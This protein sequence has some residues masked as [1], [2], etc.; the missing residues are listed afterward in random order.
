M[1]APSRQRR[2]AGYGMSLA[3]LLLATYTI[4]ATQAS[5]GERGL[6]FSDGQAAS[7]ALGQ[8]DLT[9]AEAGAG[10]TGQNDAAGVAFDDNGMMWVADT[11]NNRI[12][13]YERPFE[14]GEAATVVIGQ[15]GFD[16][17]AASASQTGLNEPFGLSFDSEGNMWVAD[18][19]NNRV[20]RYEA[21]FSTGMAASLVLGQ[22]DFDDLSLIHI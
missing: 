2:L 16:S 14:T 21:P 20:V 11:F 7:T 19:S 1:R 18:T 5:G 9:T 4:F 6:A 10:A 12:L 8:S 15:S 3:A 13:G 17:T 22:S